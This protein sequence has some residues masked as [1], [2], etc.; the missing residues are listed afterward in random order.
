MF[1]AKWFDFACHFSFEILIHF[2]S[3]YNVCFK[4]LPFRPTN[5]ANTVTNLPLSDPLTYSKRIQLL[6]NTKIQFSSD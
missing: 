2:Q 1:E 5:T 3:T 4:P 6:L